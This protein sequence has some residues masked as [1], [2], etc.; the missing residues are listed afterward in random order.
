MGGSACGQFDVDNLHAGADID[1]ELAANEG[2]GIVD[3]HGIFA[4]TVDGLAQSNGK[5][6]LAA[7][8]DTLEHQAR[9]LR[10]AVELVEND[11]RDC[12]NVG[13]VDL[14]V[15]VD[16]GGIGLTRVGGSKLL[17][18]HCLADPGDDLLNVDSRNLDILIDIAR[19]ERVVLSLIEKLVV[20][21]DIRFGIGDD[22]GQT[23][24]VGGAVFAAD[25]QDVLAQGLES[26]LDLGEYGRNDME[27]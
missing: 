5:V 6:V 10:R 2:S 16:I 25:C 14:A 22:S 17:E 19:D 21:T 8:A 15:V 11:V 23:L 18:R 3:H 26:I 7:A 24:E 9:S 13:D 1:V 20:L 4:D 12:H 27:V